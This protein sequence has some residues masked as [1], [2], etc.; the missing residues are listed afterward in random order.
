MENASKAL[1][2]AAEVLI[3]VMILAVGVY[4]FN[5]FASYSSEQYEKIESA[6]TAAFNAQF[7][8]FYGTGENGKPVECTIHDIVSLANLAQKNNI[9]Y[10]LVDEVT[11]GGKISYKKK[12]ENIN[13]ENSLYVQIDLGNIKN[14]ELKSNND[15]IK[16]IKENDL[17]QGATDEEGKKTEQKQYKCVECIFGE[18]SKRINYMKFSD[19]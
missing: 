17:T 8:Q 1:I 7:L 18:N 13:G 10:E 3:G 19:I 11:N 6:Q 14:L 4:L 5:M 16:L 9:E 2:M 15:L 12:S